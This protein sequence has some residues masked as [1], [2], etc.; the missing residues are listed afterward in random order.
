[1]K[2]KNVLVAGGAGY[3]GSHVAKALRNS[4]YNP[5]VYDNLSTGHREAVKYG[6]LVIGDLSDSSKLDWTFKNY[7][8]MAVLNFAGSI[9]VPE[10]VSEPIKY[11]ENNTANALNLIKA[12]TR[13]NIEYFIFSSTAAVYGMGQGRALTENDLTSPINPYGRSKLMTEWILEDTSKANE[14][15][16]HICLRYFN[17]AG[18]DPEGELGQTSKVSTH[19]IKL[20]CL[21]SL[22]KRDKLFLYGTDYDTTDGTCIRDYIHVSDLATAHVNALDYLIENKTSQTLNCGYGKGSS[23][24]EVISVVKEISGV[25]FKVEVT[26]RRDGDSDLLVA[27]SSKLKKLTGWKPQYQSLDIIVSSALNWEKQLTQSENL[28]H[29]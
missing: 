28:T 2:N 23:V 4:G 27:D 22:G 14:N 9:I 3:I 29:C 26:G 5:I 13:N 15:F 16:H 8:I 1:M 11:Y 18:A 21:S 20:A 17:V 7:N 25:D 6:E 12:C 10:S 19:L 24:K